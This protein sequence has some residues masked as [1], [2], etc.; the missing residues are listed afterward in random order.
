MQR[1]EPSKLTQDPQP[2]VC[3]SAVV[4][5]TLPPHAVPGPVFEVYV[6]TQVINVTC[7]MQFKEG[8]TVRI[9][10]PAFPVSTEEEKGTR[11][12]LLEE[13]GKNSIQE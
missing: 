11:E 1:I 10:V 12:S 3:F 4:H 9:N 6:G 5:L 8:D 2:T 13:Y 7:P